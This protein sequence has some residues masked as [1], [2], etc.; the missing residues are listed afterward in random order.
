MV[1]AS[2]D[3]I[4]PEL[5]DNM[6]DKHLREI[7]EHLAV[8]GWD[9]FSGPMEESQVTSITVSNNNSESDFDMCS[10]K[11]RKRMKE[12]P[13][14]KKKA[15][16][17][18]DISHMKLRDTA[19]EKCQWFDVHWRGYKR[20]TPKSYKDLVSDGIDPRDLDYVVEKG[21]KAQRTTWGGASLRSGCETNP[22]I[23]FLPRV[24]NVGCCSGGQDFTTEIKVRYQHQGSRCVPYSF[25]NVLGQVGWVF[26]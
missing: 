7:D 3:K 26:N 24:E 12:S 20:S 6:V 9:V 5:D 15:A 14:A 25:L 10:S 19:T 8:T 22:S 4:F 13:P 16:K 18:Y 23:S 1:T 17:Q 11:K 2:K 21:V